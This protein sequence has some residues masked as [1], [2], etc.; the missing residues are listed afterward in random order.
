MAKRGKRA[1]KQASG[2]ARLAAAGRVPQLLGWPEEDHDVIREAARVERLH[3]TQFVQ[4]HA[5][6]A[7]KR[8]L[9]KSSD[10]P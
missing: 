2:G 6:A 3:M 8:I 1:A 5:L 7:A 9:A 10:S 4:R